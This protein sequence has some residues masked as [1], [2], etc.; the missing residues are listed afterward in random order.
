MHFLP[1]VA[2]LSIL[3][4]SLIWAC[5]GPTRFF[6]FLKDCVTVSEDNWTWT[7]QTG[8]W[9][10]DAEIQGIQEGELVLKHRH[11]VVCLAVEA[12]SEKS[13]ELLYHTETWA[14]HLASVPARNRIT[15]FATGS[16]RRA[17]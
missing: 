5:G 2:C 1:V 16:T 14:D 10:E 3:K 13:R 15:N 4:I 11:G 17:A 9:F 12:L 8:E 6:R 7:T